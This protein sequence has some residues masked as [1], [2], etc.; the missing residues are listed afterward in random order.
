MPKTGTIQ[1]NACKLGL[2]MLA[3]QYSKHSTSI[4][5]S[6]LDVMFDIHISVHSP[7]HSQKEPL[8]CTLC[9]IAS[10][11]GV[12]LTGSAPVVDG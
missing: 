9:T 1:C 3:P 5:S 11:V 12:Y 7:V 8:I 6:N 10:K 4:Y 2:L